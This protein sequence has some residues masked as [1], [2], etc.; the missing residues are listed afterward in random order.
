LL[1]RPWIS[2]VDQHAV[3]HELGDVTFV[4][5]DLASDRVLIAADDIPQVLRIQAFGKRRGAYEVDEHHRQL[6]ALGLALRRQGGY[7]PI[8]LPFVLLIGQGRDRREQNPAVSQQDTE[9]AQILV[10]QVRK[11]AEID[12]VLDK[13]L[14]IPA[15]P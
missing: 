2:E 13:C 5:R 8:A 4:A 6:A 10:G 12:A 14:G 7:R 9:L 1:V 15:Q 3:A 11:R